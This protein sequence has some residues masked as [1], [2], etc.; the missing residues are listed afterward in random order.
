MGMTEEQLIGAARTGDEQ[1]FGK[2]VDPHRNG[3]YVHCYRMLG[4]PQDAEDALQETLLRAWRGLEAFQGRSSPRSWLYTIATNASLRAIERR[5]P[6]VLPLDHGP[7]TDPHDGP[8]GPLAES[9]WIEPLPDGRLELSEGRANPEASYEQR[10]GVELAFVAALQMLPGRQR[11]VLILREVLGFSAR[12]VAEILET[13]PPAIDSAMQR[14]R[15][16][17]EGRLPERS[18][19]TTLRSLGDEATRVIVERY[20]GAWESGD[21]EAL[22]TLLAEDA[23]ISMPPQSNWFQGR[24]AVAAFVAGWPMEHGRGWPCRLISANGQLAFAHYEVDR[25]DGSVRPHNISVIELDGALIGSI[26]AFLDPG[27]FELFEL[28]GTPG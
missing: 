17:I 9:V 10:E 12:E 13:T 21:V 24:E 11:A 3:L 23:T 28:S 2:L 5:P 6:R 8:G 18:Q 4:S 20:V 15:A 19:Q 1:A 26:I 14:A 27:L 25:E 16:T 22:K 7:P